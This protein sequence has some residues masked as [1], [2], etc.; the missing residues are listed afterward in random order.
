[1]RSKILLLLIAS[2]TLFLSLFLGV[3]GN[4]PT[5]HGGAL[6]TP[7]T[8]AR[9]APPAPTWAPRQQIGTPIE[10]PRR[11]KIL[12]EKLGIP[13]AQLKTMTATQIRELYETN[14]ARLDINV[15][16][17]SKD[18]QGREQWTTIIGRKSKANPY[19]GPSLTRLPNSINQINQIWKVFLPLVMKDSQSSDPEINVIKERIDQAKAFIDRLYQSDTNAYRGYVKEYP[20]CPIGIINQSLSGYPRLVGHY[21]QNKNQ[22]FGKVVWYAVGTQYDLSDIDF[23][24][25]YEWNW[26]EPLAGC[27]RYYSYGYPG[28]LLYEIRKLGWTSNYTYWVDITFADYLAIQDAWSKPNSYSVEVVQNPSGAFAAHRY[29]VRHASYLGWLLYTQYDSD[30]MN[31]LFY[32]KDNYG[33]NVDIYDPM[34]LNSYDYADDFM[35]QNYAYHDCDLVNQGINST[36]PYGYL[37][38]RYP[39]ESKVCLSRDAYIALSRLDRLAPILQ[40]IHILIKYNNP[41]YV[42]PHPRGW[43]TTTPRQMA[44]EIESCC[45]NGYG[46]NVYLKDPIYASSVRTNAFLVL[47]TLLG[48]AV[49][50]TTSRYYA[51]QTYNVL[52]QVQWGMPPFALYQGE[53]ADDGTITRPQFQGGQLLS[54][55]TGGSFLYSLPPRTSLLN[56]LLD[57]MGMPKE[58]EGPIPSN[59]ETTLTYWQALRVYLGFKYGV[60]YPSGF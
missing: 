14:A 36:L 12:N 13:I 56:D 28:E 48:Y 52:K 27:D 35:F 39:Y 10:T 7:T 18:A 51:D 50:D 4:P 29:T 2:I 22:V 45:W 33:F 23:D 54:W 17:L 49:G 55:R 19:P 40:A 20:G 6:P 38:H 59:A 8:V 30:R 25:D 44:R 21:Y 32:L 60:W 37:P 42:Y 5:I 53:T 9:K 46:I 1:M 11:L 47:E 34:F 26:G 41:D 15:Y 3:G 43:G 16:R 57:L 31:R 58:V 24:A